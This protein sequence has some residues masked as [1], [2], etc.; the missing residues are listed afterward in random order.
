MRRLGGLF[1]PVEREELARKLFYQA[2]ATLGAVSGL[3]V[4]IV[5]AKEPS[6]IDAAR[7]GGARVLEETIQLS[8]SR[9]AECGAK[10]ALDLGAETV[11]S[12]PI[13]VPLATV[14]DYETLLETS[15]QPPSPSL[16]IVPSFD[17]TGTNAL[18]RNPPGVIA[19]QFGPGSFEKH[20]SAGRAAGAEVQVLRPRG[21]TLDLD[22]P[23]DLLEIERYAQS[24]N[25]VLNFL[26]EINAFSRARTVAATRLQ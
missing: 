19:S 17:G 1:S 14:A 23:E 22:T 15:G 25:A 10:M 3:D 11:L 12:A 9:A 18:V 4:L 2:L 8:H 7:C 5:V 24:S 13:D 16:I 6:F 26:A 21:L 20:L